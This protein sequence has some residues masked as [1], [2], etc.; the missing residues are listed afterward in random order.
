MS[1]KPGVKADAA[2]SLPKRKSHGAADF[3]Q[4]GG[5]MAFKPCKVHEGGV[6]KMFVGDRYSV[7]TR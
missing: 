5:R 3:L 6:L 7:R 1:A 4:K 2:G